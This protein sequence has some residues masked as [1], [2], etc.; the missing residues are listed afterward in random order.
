MI[1]NSK[2]FFKKSV[3]DDY[4]HSTLQLRNL[5]MLHFIISV[6]LALFKKGLYYCFQF[7]FYTHH[8]YIRFKSHKVTITLSLFFS[9][10]IQLFDLKFSY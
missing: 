3:F 10:I 9:D 4:F 1:S 6:L 8:T 5:V 2:I 7:E